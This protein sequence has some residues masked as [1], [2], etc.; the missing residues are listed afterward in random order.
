MADLWCWATGKSFSHWSEFLESHLIVLHHSWP[1]VTQQF[2]SYSVGTGVDE[3]I[4]LVS[5][6]KTL[7]QGIL[8]LFGLAEMNQVSSAADIFSRPEIT[9]IK[10][11]IKSCRTVD[12]EGCS[13]ILVVKLDPTLFSYSAHSPP[14]LVFPPGWAERLCD[15]D[16]PHGHIGMMT[17]PRRQ[18]W[19]Q[20][21]WWQ[22]WASV[23]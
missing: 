3:S 22:Q 1:L 9:R 8:E 16:P 15:K 4:S 10:E 12:A 13:G 7:K 14:L 17:P 21:W 18:W 11:I 2:T 23:K 5:T 20:W 6:P 19:W